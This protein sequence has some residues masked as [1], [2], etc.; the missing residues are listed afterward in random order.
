MPISVDKQGL[1][2]ESI[3]PKHMPQQTLHPALTGE[4]RPGFRGECMQSVGY[5]RAADYRI[6]GGN[7]C[8]KCYKTKILS[9]KKK[10]QKR[11]EII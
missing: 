2:K 7:P 3:P 10:L 1:T 5:S 4:L 11:I 8:E 9:F 6:H